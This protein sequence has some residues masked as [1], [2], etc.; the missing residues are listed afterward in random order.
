MI[1]SK[2]LVE[3]NGARITNTIGRAELA[4]IAT[5]L[6][7]GY[8]HIATDNLSSPHQ[9]RKQILYPEKHRRHA[10]G[11]VLETISNLART[12]QG[13]ILF[14]KVKPHAGIAENFPFIE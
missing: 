1:D 10:Q 4:A 13:H 5:A 2:N 8:T 3:P 7:N 9:L 6:A 14:Y 12:S 11:D